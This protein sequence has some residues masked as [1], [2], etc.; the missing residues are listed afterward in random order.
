MFDLA[1]TFLLASKFCEY[2]ILQ[3][4]IVAAFDDV[5]T[6]FLSAAPEERS[7]IYLKGEAEAARLQGKAAGYER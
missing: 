5:I 4:G 6:E 7:S 3:A 1:P 2:H